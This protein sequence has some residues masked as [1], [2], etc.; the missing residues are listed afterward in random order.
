MTIG[1]IT[2]AIPIKWPNIDYAPDMREVSS[3]IQGMQQ[4]GMVVKTGKKKVALPGKISKITGDPVSGGYRPVNLYSVDPE[5]K[6][7]TGAI[8]YTAGVRRQIS[9]VTGKETKS[10]TGDLELVTRY[11]NTH[12][13]TK[14]ETIKRILDS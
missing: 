2:A 1:E 10:L 11:N 9:R 8:I 14:I 7:H 6:N 13:L 5:Y 4:K 12:R 3:A